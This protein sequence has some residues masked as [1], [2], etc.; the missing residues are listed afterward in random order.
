MLLLSYS[1]GKPAGLGVGCICSCLQGKSVKLGMTVA[2]YSALDGVVRYWDAQY[3]KHKRSVSGT[4][5]KSFP[6]EEAMQA[7]LLL[8]YWLYFHGCYLPA[9]VLAITWPIFVIC[10]IPVL[11]LR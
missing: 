9:M 6:H 4:N 10:T 2:V 1:G 3:G 8:L 5:S 7:E 11:A